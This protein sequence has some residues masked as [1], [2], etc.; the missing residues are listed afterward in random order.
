MSGTV[1]AARQPHHGVFI[2]APGQVELRRDRL[3][4]SWFEGDYV[5]TE[6][7]GNSVCSSDQKAVR[8]FTEHARIPGDATQVAL[9]HET[10]HRVVAAPPEHAG[11]SRTGRA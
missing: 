8:Q 7:L 9:G 4:A 2:T 3:P 6:S 11:A 5:I 10:V 1:E